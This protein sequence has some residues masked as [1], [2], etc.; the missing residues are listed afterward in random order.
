MRFQGRI[1][2]I[3]TETMLRW[4]ELVGQLEGV[5]RPA[6]ELREAVRPAFLAKYRWDIATDPEYDT[7]IQVR[8]TKVLAWGSHGDGRWRLDDPNRGGPHA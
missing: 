4:G 1:A 6:P 2:A 5:A 3:T 8:P 7:V